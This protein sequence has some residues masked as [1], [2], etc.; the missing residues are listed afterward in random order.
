MLNLSRLCVLITVFITF[1]VSSSEKL[2]EIHVLLSNSA[3]FQF[4]GTE[5]LCKLGK[6]YLVPLTSKL[7]TFGNF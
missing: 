2:G 4:K 6:E 3:L 7:C 1:A 5:Y